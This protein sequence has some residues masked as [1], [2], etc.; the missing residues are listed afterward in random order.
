MLVRGENFL[1]SVDSETRNADQVADDALNAQLALEK[2]QSAGNR[3]N[4]VVLYACR[5]NPFAVRS[6]SPSTG[7]ATT[8]APHG[9]MVAYATSPGSV[10]TNG[11][12]ANGR[13][14]EHL[15]RMIAQPGLLVEEVLK[16]VRTLVR[17]DSNVQQTRWENTKLEGQSYF[18]PPPQA[19]VTSVPSLGA[20]PGR[21]AAPDNIALALSFWDT[22]K[23]S[24][25]VDELESYVASL[26][27][28][29]LSAI[30][31]TRIASL[32]EANRPSAAAPADVTSL[33]PRPGVTRPHEEPTATAA[34]APP[35]AP[36]AVS[37]GELM[38]GTTRFVGRFAQ[39]AD[40]YRQGDLGQRRYL[41]G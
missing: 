24:G 20:R 33:L 38:A 18:R 22:V 39:D 3:V 9:S 32:R 12:G 19:A 5:N 11:T 2:M 17:R 6:R 15:A 1:V 10:A 34:V 35:A 8:S 31:R 41:R 27:Q 30:A 21:V 29:P 25:S 37:S 40:R 28:G 14:T 26:L 7:L 16:Q 4:L 36:A 23:N 13:H